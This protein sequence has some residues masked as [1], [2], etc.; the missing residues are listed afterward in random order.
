M[1][2]LINLATSPGYWFRQKTLYS[3]FELLLSRFCALQ[4]LYTIA[5]SLLGIIFVHLWLQEHKKRKS[6]KF[7][8]FNLDK[9]NL[10]LI[11]T[12]CMVLLIV[13]TWLGR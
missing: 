6:D 8:S 12:L 5:F 9:E 1:N 2:I 13:G 11:S 10:Y 7:I 4:I 3:D